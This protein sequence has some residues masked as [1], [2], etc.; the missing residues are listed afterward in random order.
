[1]GG[2][3]PG[4]EDGGGKAPRPA[5]ADGPPLVKRPQTADFPPQVLESMRQVR[6]LVDEA[7]RRLRD[8][9]V[10]DAFLGRM[11]MSHAEFR[12]FVAGWQRELEKAAP[13]AAAPGP[14]TARSAA[15][16]TGELLQGNTGGAA[17][18]ASAAAPEPQVV[19]AGQA[20]VSARLRPAVETYFKALGRLG[21]GPPNAKEG[22]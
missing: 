16:G 4:A 18:A 22:G 3:A 7:D 17:V 10:T 1:V 12:R 5:R 15:A 13:E 2:G 14:A 19:E 21:A 9:E 11:G 6:R 20:R 8:G